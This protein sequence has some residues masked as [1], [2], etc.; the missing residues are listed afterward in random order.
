[1]IHAHAWYRCD[2]AE[3]TPLADIVRPFGTALISSDD[4]GPKVLV[5]FDEDADGQ[6]IEDFESRLHE[7]RLQVSR[8]GEII[9]PLRHCAAGTDGECNAA[10]C[11][12]TRDGEPEK[13]GRF[14]PLPHWSDERS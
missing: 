8:I 6:W 1:M 3:L 2:G 9:G 10:G 5:T 4:A 11:P 14:C 7:S 13:S 12:Q